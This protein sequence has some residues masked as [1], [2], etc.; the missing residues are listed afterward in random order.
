MSTHDAEEPWKDIARRKRAQRDAAIPVDWRLD[1]N[2]LPKEDG[3]TENV[4]AVP[5]QCAILSAEELQITSNYDARGIIREITSRRMTAKQVTTA[6]CKRAAIAQQLTN[7]LTEPLFASAL[8]RADFLDTYLAERGTALGPLHGLPISMKDTFNIAGVDSSIGVAAL[9]FK[10]ATSNSPLVELLLSLGCVIIAKT[11]VPQTLAAL[12]SNN[13]VF[14]RTMNP[15]NRLVT[16]GGS[17]G[18]EGVLVAMRGSMIGVGTDIGG[19]I[20]VPAMCNAV[21]GF[22]PS[23]GRVPHGGQEGGSL[24]ANGRVGIQAVTGPI[25]RSV[26]DLETFLKEVVPRSEMWGDDC[27]PGTWTQEELRGSG[28]NGKF[29]VGILRRDGNCEPLPPVLKVLEEVKQKLSLT[30]N[31]H[32]I[33]LSTPPAWTK[34]QSL[35]GRLIG[36]DGATH[37]ADLLEQTKEPLVTWMQGRF[38][39]GRPRSFSEMS[40]MQA[41]RSDLE[42]QMLDIWYSADERGVRERK[43]DAIIC[44]VAPHP[45]PPIDR[46]NAVGYTSSFVLLDYPAGVIPVRKFNEGDLELGKQMADSAL[47]SW[48]RRNRELWD[49]KVT[50]RKLYLGTP[51]S[52]QIVTPKLHDFELCRMMELIDRALTAVHRLSKL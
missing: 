18:G 46:W 26:Q 49:E 20:R 22:K 34:C 21:Y 6:F 10:P 13:N 31:I 44:P 5:H 27:V 39:R 28:D 16:A 32:V 51:L 37:M 42:R 23:V 7:C 45:V 36:A 25:A 17:S 8:Q 40:G 52:I 2:Y 43:V 41:A 38:K 4:L 35:A 30:A 50:D 47:G 15:I 48:D 3:R 29:V 9:C 14:G 33:N 19:S 11:N 12:D 24:C 1:H